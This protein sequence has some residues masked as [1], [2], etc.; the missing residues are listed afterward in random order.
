MR[1]RSRLAGLAPLLALAACAEF[2]EK[3]ENV[4]PGE[5]IRPFAI[6]LDPP[7]AAPGDT[8][9]V[10]L[11]IYEA[12]KRPSV[13]WDMALKYQLNQGATSS[14]FPSAEAEVD[15]ETGGRKL[16]PSADGLAFSVV[17][18]AGDANPLRLTGMAPAV[19]REEAG[20]SEE[21]K[22]ALASIGIADLA[23]GLGKDRLID[24]LEKSDSVPNAL[25]PLVDGLI[26]LV[27][28]RAKVAAPGFKLDVTKTLTVRYSNRL[29][30]GPFLSNV[31]GN[32]VLDSIGFI[33]VRAKDVT[34][35]TRIAEH[36]SD[37][38]FFATHAETDAAD[39]RYDTLEVWPDCSYFLIAK[40]DGDGQP[41]RSPAGIGHTEQLFFQWFYSNLDATGRDWDE[42][43]GLADSDRPA[44]LP[45]VPVRI[46][47]AAAG[48]RHF[49]IRATVGDARPEWGALSS[50][51]LDYKA[52]YG[53]LRYE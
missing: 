7:E 47:K 51:G 33:R 32:P 38:L 34:D 24:A 22:R 40:T 26:G 41:Y 52:I 14:A 9:K 43:L 25:A 1:F 31:N 49:S 18:P 5:K 39:P 10:R 53:Y 23:S 19:L 37:T 28:F 30:S 27:R 4:I 50:A 36:Q 17:I 15:L 8:V 44:S 46:P 2:P 42:L 35:F 16:G 12:G 21:E 20:L 13:A 6:I 3:Y 29:R 48:L 45:V 11:V